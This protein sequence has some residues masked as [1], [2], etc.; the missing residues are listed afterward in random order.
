MS[1]PPEARRDRR[2]R[3]QELACRRSPEDG[4]FASASRSRWPP[5]AA[6]AS[7]V[8][9]RQYKLFAAEAGDESVGRSFVRMSCQF[10]STKSPVGGRLLI[11]DALK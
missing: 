10:A 1:W 9:E 3:R 11:I 7:E 8:C 5:V 6:P 2:Y 4:H